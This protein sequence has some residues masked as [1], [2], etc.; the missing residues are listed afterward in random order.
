MARFPYQFFDEYVVR[1]PLFSRE[2][3]QKNVNGCSISNEE[4]KAIC[5]NSV[6]H[7]AI[8]LASPYVYNEL[9]RWLNS[10]KEFSPKEFQKLKT[11]IL[12]YFS[13][14]STRCTP[15]GLFSEVG[16]GTFSNEPKNN[17]NS[18][19]NKIRDTKLDMHFLVGLSQHF[20][21]NPEIRNHLLFFPNNSIYQV[22]SKIR[23]VEYE[24]TKEKRE[25]IISSAPLSQ[26]LQQVLSFSGQGKT[27]QQIAK[28]LMNDEITEEEA[29]EF[30]DELIDNQVLISEL[31]PIV[32]GSDVLEVIISVLNRIGAKNENEILVSIQKRLKE[33]DQ[34]IGNSA[35]SYAEIEK[36]IQSFNVEYKSN[37]LFQTDLYYKNVINLPSFWKKE[38]KQA[39][40]FLNKISLPQKET[41][42]DK[43][44]KAF[45]ERFETQEVSLSYA[46][47]TEVGIGYQQDAA[48]KG[49]HSYLEN[50][51]LPLPNGKSNLKIEFDPIQQVLNEKLQKA[52]LHSQYIINLS[53][54]DFKG[55]DENWNDL[56]DTI[57]FMAEIISQNN[58][59]K[60][61]L[62]GGGGSSAA[63]LLGRFCSEK[64]GVQDLTQKITQKEEMLRQ[65]QHDNGEI[66]AEIIH[67][68]EARIGNI[69]RRPILRQ[70][71]I[72]YLAQ[73]V[74][75]E[76]NQIPVNDLYISLKNNKIVLRSKRF[77][78]EVKPY[79]TN[80]HNYSANPLPVYH[81]LCDLY[82]Q[83]IRSGLYFNW[84]DLKYIYNFLP[85]VE[86]K[87]IILSK[88]SWKITNKE[89]NKFSLLI[90][91]KDQLFTELEN[92]R[93]LKQIPQWIQWVKSDNKLTVN[94]KNYDLVKMLIDSVKNEESIVIEEFLYN[95]H[96][97]FKREFIFPMYKA[98]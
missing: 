41:H 36:L 52:L 66:L 13:R 22:G 58:R 78:K 12:K 98:K 9:I 76:E 56:P 5:K 40:S 2:N 82:S 89:I 27:M 10:E 79:L 26:A 77:N 39:I 62:N 57:S 19:V 14:T 97:D 16:L 54:E 73:S 88:A 3:F 24:Y 65:A 75:P 90:S 63:N 86:Y 6:F 7:E 87:N 91:D 15:F 51:E 42:L 33:L 29:I 69:I 55:F 85:R 37:H 44:K 84:G 81:F 18:N 80:A 74:L 96:D 31:E 45:Y 48:I 60:L 72:P 71:E 38:L 46:L 34:N 50:L 67:L 1:T 47:D 32:S 49:L 8:Y 4:L 94:L 83:N 53:D 64:S 25:Y 59:E 92:W 35:S 95:E 70:Y 28:I 11:T 61:F 68:P 43:F 21:Q 20:V 30:I 93:K 23:F 17:Y